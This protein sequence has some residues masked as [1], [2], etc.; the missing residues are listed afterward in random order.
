[1]TMRFPLTALAFERDDPSIDMLL[2]EAAATAKAR[3]LR[4][5]GVVQRRGNGDDECHC[6]ATDLVALGSGRVFNISQPLGDGARGCRLD[7]GALAQCCRHLEAEVAAGCDV[8]VLNR[9]GKAE[10]EGRGFRDLIVMALDRDI[11]V[12]AGVR[13]EYAAAWAEFGQELATLAPVGRAPLDAWLEGL[14]A[15]AWDE[16]RFADVS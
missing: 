2:E 8:L 15:P 10:A 9:F 13:G 6:S 3:G 4:V 11:P 12:L 16:A 14:P 7:P 1:M 5:S